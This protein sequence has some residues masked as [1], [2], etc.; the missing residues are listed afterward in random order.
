MYKLV[1]YRPKYDHLLT[2][3]VA[4]LALSFRKE[5]DDIR[6]AKRAIKETITGTEA[7]RLKFD[8]ASEHETFKT[9]KINRHSIKPSHNT[10]VAVE[11]DLKNENGQIVV[12]SRM[13]AERFGKRHADVIRVIEEKIEINAK[14]RS[15][16][17]YIENTYIDSMNRPKKEY[18]MTRDGFTFIVMGFTGVEADKFKLA[19]IEAFNKMEEALK[20]QQPAL[21]TTYKEALVALVAEVEAKERLQLE[22]AEQQKQIEVMK[23]K[24]A[25][26]DVVLMADGT[27]P[28]TII[29]KDYGMSAK[30]MNKILHECGVQYKMGGTWVLYAQ[31]QGQGYTSSYTGVECETQFGDYAYVSTRW[32]QKGRMF[33]YD[34]LKEHG[35]LPE[36]ER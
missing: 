10:Q 21:P 4:F 7:W 13:V 2:L 26:C 29:A 14:L 30:A 5:S 11:N 34:T 12:S 18:L 31:H 32:T 3:D 8:D 28:I 1:Y 25:Y 36:M 22:N 15:S 9:K 24:S 27:V 16:N 35:I 20:V 23:P 6:I 17:F 33:I 19:Y